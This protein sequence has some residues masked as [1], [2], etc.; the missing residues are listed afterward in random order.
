MTDQDKSITSLQKDYGML[1]QRVKFLEKIVYGVIGMVVLQL[2]GLF[3]LWAKQV[4][5]DK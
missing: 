2:V 3:I 5:I 4:L 1:E